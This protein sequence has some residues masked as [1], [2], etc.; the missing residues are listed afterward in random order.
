MLNN[1]LIHSNVTPVNLSKSHR[2]IHPVPF[3]SKRKPPTDTHVEISQNNICVHALPLLTF[4]L[5][6]VVNPDITDIRKLS[7]H[8]VRIISCP[9]WEQSFFL[10]EL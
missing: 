5:V 10:E 7:Y 9:D 2:V 3:F 8:D 4:H 1:A 6:S